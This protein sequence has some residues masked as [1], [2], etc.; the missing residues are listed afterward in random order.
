MN[1][2]LFTMP[3]GKQTKTC[4]HKKNTNQSKMMSIK[5][6]GQ[7]YFYLYMELMIICTHKKKNL[8]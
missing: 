4:Y 1:Q 5:Q 2:S 7:K 3:H 8:K 6:Q